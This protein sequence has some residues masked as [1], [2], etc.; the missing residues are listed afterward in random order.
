M[1]LGWI[2]LAFLQKLCLK[3]SKLLK[4]NVQAY[5]TPVNVKEVDLVGILRFSEEFYFPP[6]PV[7]PSLNNLVKKGHVEF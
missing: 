7:L 4:K 5:P 6:N 2:R 3:N 1:R